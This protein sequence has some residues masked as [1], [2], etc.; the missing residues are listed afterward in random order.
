[1]KTLERKIRPPWWSC[2]LKGVEGSYPEES[3]APFA[4]NVADETWSCRAQVQPLKDQ[5]RE[6][7]QQASVLANV[8]QAFE[9]DEGAQKHQNERSRIPVLEA[10]SASWCIWCF[11]DKYL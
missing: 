11:K 7:G 9:S 4:Q 3:L 6:H 10:I 5:D 2:R 8:A 1:M